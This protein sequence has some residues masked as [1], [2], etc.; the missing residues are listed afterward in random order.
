MW[1]AEHFHDC[2]YA[3]RD[4]IGFYLGLTA[5]LLWVVAQVGMTLMCS[6]ALHSSHW[7]AQA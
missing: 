1:I 7:I 5:I 6:G 4:Y 2:V 3:L